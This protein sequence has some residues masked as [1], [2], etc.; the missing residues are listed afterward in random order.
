MCTL[1]FLDINLGTDVSVIYAVMEWTMPL[2]LTIPKWIRHRVDHTQ[3]VKKI[4]DLKMIFYK[5]TT[6]VLEL[7]DICGPFQSNTPFQGNKHILFFIDNF[8]WMKFIYFI[9]SK[10]E[11]QNKFCIF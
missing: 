7:Y 2:V 11:V 1:T 3:K 6:S 10:A 4:G 5:K 8:S 9:S